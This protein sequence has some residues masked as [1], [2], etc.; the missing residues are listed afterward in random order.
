[1]ILRENEIFLF[2]NFQELVI[3]FL[4]RTNEIRVK[5]DEGE[6]WKN[7]ILLMNSLNK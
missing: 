5:R 1:M 2:S 7:L 6:L 4:I 3:N